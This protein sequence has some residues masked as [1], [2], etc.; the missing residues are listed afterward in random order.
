[1][2]Y[3][4]CSVISFT[5]MWFQLDVEKRPASHFSCLTVQKLLF[6]QLLKKAYDPDPYFRVFSDFKARLL[7]RQNIT[8]LENLVF[9]VLSRCSAKMVVTYSSKYLSRFKTNLKLEIPHFCSSCPHEI[10]CFL[11][12][13]RLTFPWAARK[14]SVSFESPDKGPIEAC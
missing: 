5:A 13:S 12:S 4:L 9:P 10:L 7:K 8:L 2:T 1:M 6:L 11:S 3:K 14:H